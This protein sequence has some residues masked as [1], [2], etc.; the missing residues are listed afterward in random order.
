[1]PVLTLLLI[2]AGVLA[3]CVV[4]L[5]LLSLQL[6]DVSFVDA[7]WP[8]GMVVVALTTYFTGGS[9]TIR[10][11]LLTGLVSLWGLRLGLYLF[12]RWRRQGADPR[13]TAMLS[14]A[15][16]VR[17]WS[18]ARASLLLVFALQAPLQLIVALPV[19][20]GQLDPGGRLDLMA[21]AGAVLAVFGIGYEALAD[22]QLAAFKADPAMSGKI[23]DR[24]LWRYSRH[25]NYFGEAC[26]WWGMYLA[27]AGTPA[28]VYSIVGPVLITFLLTKGSGAPTVE[29]RMKGRRPGY[30][31]YMRRT[32]SFIPW[33]PR[34]GA[35]S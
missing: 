25:P 15:Q 18:F 10:A 22:G 8:L 23:M 29:G 16:A 12:A 20:L 1:M 2:N 17:G 31:E 4:L 35:A 14:H 6:K 28:G 7:W 27:A 34:R 13:Y 30:E 11:G 33:P 9:R 26:A 3:V 5:W 21:Y 24:G 19:Q 32:S